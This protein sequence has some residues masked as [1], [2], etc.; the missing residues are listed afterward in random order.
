MGGIGSFVRVVGRALRPP[1]KAGG[2]GLLG[3]AVGT[4]VGSRLD[5]SLWDTGG[6]FEGESLT[7]AAPPV[8]RSLTEDYGPYAGIGRLATM[9]GKRALG[10]PATLAYGA[11][12]FA[13]ERYTGKSLG[14]H[15]TRAPGELVRGATSMYRV[16]SPS[17]KKR[18]R[19]KHW[20]ISK[21][22]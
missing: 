1:A 12:D 2:A 21:G 14:H 15:I 8:A 10:L 6:D 20:Q 17:K 9:V 13:S 16:L 22:Y 19:P 18:E 4:D 5:Q 7:K 3:Y 11:A